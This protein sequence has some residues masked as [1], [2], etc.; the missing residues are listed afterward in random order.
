VRH[1][2]PHSRQ[3]APAEFTSG[4]FD[5]SGDRIDLDVTVGIGSVIVTDG[6]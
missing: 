3:P 5:A 4:P 1:L 2:A 6:A